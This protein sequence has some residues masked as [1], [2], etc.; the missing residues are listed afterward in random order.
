MLWYI[1]N[2]PQLESLMS[3][4]QGGI[5]YVAMWYAKNSKFTMNV[6]A[7]CKITDMQSSKVDYYILHS[8]S[9]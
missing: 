3:P 6:T 7:L 5:L 8:N 1:S 4:T 2:I 9:G